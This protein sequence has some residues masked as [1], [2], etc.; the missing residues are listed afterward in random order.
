MPAARSVSSRCVSPMTRGMPSRLASGA[1]GSLGALV[2]AYHV[3]TEVVQLANDPRT[4]GAKAGHDHVSAEGGCPAPA[5]LGRRALT[6][7]AVTRGRKAIPA[8]VWRN[9]A[10]FSSA[11]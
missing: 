9:C 10:H 2:Y 8:K 6:I 1:A 11:G 5:V 4:D 7:R 3:D